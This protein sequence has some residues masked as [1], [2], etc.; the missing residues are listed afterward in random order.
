MGCLYTPMKE[1][2]NLTLVEYD[3]VTCKAKDCG[4]A[5]FGLHECVTALEQH[6]GELSSMVLS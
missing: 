1:C 3:P 4:A 2:E 5:A 6:C